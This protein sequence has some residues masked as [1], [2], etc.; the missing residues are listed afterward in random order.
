MTS[1]NRSRFVTMEPYSFLKA[2]TKTSDV[3]WK[4]KINDDFKWIYSV[5]MNPNLYNIKLTFEV[6]NVSKRSTGKH[7]Q[8][9]VTIN[10]Q[11]DNILVCLE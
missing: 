3:N 8:N 6:E 4:M 11:E 10:K 5:D 1:F 9:N 2:V 7:T